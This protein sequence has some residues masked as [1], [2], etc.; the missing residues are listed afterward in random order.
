M[1]EKTFDIEGMTCS[2]CQVHVEK[3]ISGI[4]GVKRVDV[5]LMTHKARVEGDVSNEDIEK[6]VADSGYK[7]VYKAEDSLKTV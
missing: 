1:S 2:S 3:A 7:V 5:N 6:A 4:E